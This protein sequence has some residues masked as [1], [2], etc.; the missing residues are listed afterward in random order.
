MSFQRIAIVNRGEPAMRLI[1]AVAEYNVEHGTELRTIALHT[2]PDRH[3]LFVREADETYALGPAT[4]TDDAGRRRVAYVDYDLLE[5]ALTATGAEA[6]W[7][8]WG[9]VSEHADFVDLCKRLG[10]T[11]IGPDADV[12]RRLGDK[13]TSKLIAEE[14]GVPVAPWSRGPAD[15]IDAARAAAEALGYPVM[16]KATAGGGGRGIRKVMTADELETAFTSAQAE[17]LGGFGNDTVFLES[18]VQGARHIEVQI[19]GDRHGTVW[20][21]GVRDCTVQR[22][23]QKIVEEA[24]SPALSAE[25]HESI[26][27]AAARLGAAAGYHGAGTVEFLYDDAADAFAFMEVN[28]RLQ[29]EHPIT[30]ETTGLDLVKAQIHVALG[31]AL[32]GDPPTT[33]GHAIEA[34]INAEDPD[35]G[36]APSPGEI[37]LLR[38]PLGPG[39]RIDTGVEEGDAVT[40]EFDSMVAKIIA[41]GRDRDE[42]RSRLIRA[43]DQARIVIREG[44]SNKAFVQMLLNHP[45]FINNDIDVSWVDRLMTDQRGHPARHEAAALLS[46]AITAYD[47][48]LRNSVD[49]FRDA[50]NHG[51]PEVDGEIGQTVKLRF[52]GEHY[53]LHVTQLGPHRYRVDADDLTVDAHVDPLGR[54][55]DRLTCGAHTHRVLSVVHGAT[56][57]VEVDG[58]AHRITHDEG[59][60]IRAP[61][62]SVVVSMSVAPGDEV[63]AGD[64]LAIIEAMKMETSL[65]AEFPAV[66]REVLVHENVQVGTGT[67]L[68]ILDPMETDDDH[69][70]RQRIDL[71]PHASEPDGL[72]HRACRHHLEATKSMLL[73]YDVD[74]ATIAAMAAPGRPECTAGRADPDTL[75]LEDDVLGIFVDVIS[76]FRRTPDDDGDTDDRRSSE[77]YLFDYLRDLGAHSASLP[78]D[79]LEQLRTTVGHFGVDRIDKTTPHLV[80]ALFRIV[81]SHARMDD[82]TDAVLTILEDRLSRNETLDRDF[83]NLL[84]RLTVE[85]RGRYPAIHDIAL[86]LH[87]QAYD[88]PFLAQVRERAYD[89]VLDLLQRLETDPSPDQRAAIIDQLVRCSQPLKPLLSQRFAN[90]EP[91][92]QETLLEVMTRRYYR[93]RDLG[94]FTAVTR[95]GFVMTS[96]GYRYENRDIS[97]VSTHVHHDE[98]E[99]VCR[100]LDAE[101]ATHPETADDVADIYVW[102]P[103][104]PG[105]T[106]NVERA[107]RTILNETLGRRALRRIVVAVSNPDIGRSIAGV[108]NFTYRPDG[109]GGYTE[110]SQYRDLHPM[111]GKRLELWRLANFDFQ[112]LPTLSDIYLFHATAKDNPRDERLIAM[113]EVRDLTPIRDDDGVAVRV[114]EFERVFR[115]VLG[116]IRRFQAHRPANRRLHWNR[117][118]LYVWPELTFTP[119]EIATLTRRL[120]PLTTGLGLQRVNVRVRVRNDRGE[121]EAQVLEISNPGRAGV[122]VKVKQPAT[123]PI[124]S[125]SDFNQKVVRLRQR[126]LVHP[127]EIVR[128]LAPRPSETRRGLPEGEFVEYDFN[129]EGDLVP[130]DRGRGQNTANIVVGV[131][132]NKTPRYPEGMKRVILLGD[133]TRGMG[134][135]AEPECSRIMAGLDLAESLDVPVEWFAVSA[136]ALISMDSG[137]E[138]MDW[139][140]R[141]LRRIIEFT[142]AGHEIN[143]IVVG[144][145]VGAQPYWNAEATMLMHTK[146]ILVMT[147]NAAMVLTGKEALDYS[148]GVS[149]EDNLG[150]GGYERIMG[151]NGQAQYLARDLEDACRLLLRHYEFAYTAPGERFARPAASTDPI[152]RD[153]QP[154]PHGGDFATVG[155]VFS[156][157]ENPERKRPF[158]IR[159][160]M[161]AALDTDQD[162]L[163]RWFGMQHAEVAVVWDGFLGGHPVCMIGIESK[164]VPRL[165]F[166]PADGPL[167]WTSGTLFPVASKKVARAIN[168]AS[169]NRPLVVLAN[170]SGFDGSPESMRRWQ[171]EYGAEIGRAV[172]N[173]DGPIV[174]CVVSRY[175]GGA[176]V[177]FSGTLND[178]M[179]VAAVAG[180]RASV[181]GGAPAAAVVFTRD[182]RNRVAK[183]PRIIELNQRLSDADGSRKADLRRQLQALRREVQAEKMGEVAEEFDGT[184]TVER[185][186]HVG[187]VDR[188]IAPEELRPYLIDAVRR[189]IAST[190]DP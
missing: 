26:A 115:D 3:A 159:K 23:N 29:V 166:V 84:D 103:G 181:I 189:G 32:E 94:P 66:V 13:I 38:L 118:M 59:G 172:V 137:T 170:L 173:F 113:A 99:R 140:G 57:F 41:T 151:P 153:V 24:P 133:P 81:S 184:H 110:D 79:F 132:S 109:N 95:D 157:T 146:G 147:P 63:A 71:S 91:A 50:A 86:E 128:M 42:A 169:G 139:I 49:A 174:F 107:I 60:V 122:R 89:D 102:H 25:Q 96:T 123:H 27:A 178:H 182:V 40:P 31:G 53:E 160:I 108:L 183:D 158:E 88:L 142:Q 126:G 176:F 120:A 7:V 161:E 4:V 2:D 190:T 67:P 168:A 80:E 75:A 43:L 138:N 22:R 106:A 8:G 111:M 145:N 47:E 188:I 1:N 156:M 72:T 5:Q 33:S 187:S 119:D 62:P 36:F 28:A 171:L 163:E 129:D 35:R 105:M 116:P 64:R 68:L 52:G 76:L 16:I 186:Q 154:S 98:L 83:A 112:R 167:Q 34:R 14:A 149:A 15:D 39:I 127:H 180:S 124:N 70:A 144:I 61:S 114:P 175:H 162:R 97:V 21:V 58:V 177:V 55:G 9:F 92:L 152:D 141:V 136:G 11:F 101:L 143:V 10:V 78:E 90:E 56:H 150:I 164:P 30:E 93:I 74:P 17:A 6:V 45:D 77:E 69:D 148:G 44:A 134:N 46:A 73:G 87:H 131:I 85:T 65:V 117:I 20:P 155:D 19:I 37:E 179:E 125:L 104:S 135:L 165:G 12:M 185:A 100:A 82:H 51:R 130:V 121:I 54:T 18:L 48:Q